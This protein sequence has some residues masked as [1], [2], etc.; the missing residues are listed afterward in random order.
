MQI[1]PNSLDR[2]TIESEEKLAITQSEVP[3]R[4]RFTLS[5]TPSIVTDPK[6][7][8]CNDKY[9][10]ECQNKTELFRDKIISEL[11]RIQT[12]HYTNDHNNFYNVNYIKKNFNKTSTCL[13][14]K[15]QIK[16]LRTKDASYDNKEIKNL[17]PKW[18]LFGKKGINKT[19]SCVIVSSAGS[20]INSNLGEFIGNIN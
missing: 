9:S 7:F 15:S 18:K 19:E 20:L 10:L 4:P 2:V 11:R 8:M 16:T 3:N 13:A 1:K 12:E 6:K 17:L 5:K 14:Y